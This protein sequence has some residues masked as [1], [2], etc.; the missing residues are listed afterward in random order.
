MCLCG[1]L[2]RRVYCI[3]GFNFDLH[4]QICFFIYQLIFIRILVHAEKPCF[5]NGNFHDLASLIREGSQ[6]TSPP[7][8]FIPQ[9]GFVYAVGLENRSVVH[10]EDTIAIL[11]YLGLGIGLVQ[12]DFG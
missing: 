12:N 3:A 9:C 11:G 7:W 8:L 5:N 10:H 2:L 1:W 6:K 4:F